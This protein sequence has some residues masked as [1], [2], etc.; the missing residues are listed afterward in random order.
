[1]YCC[2][3]DNT[4]RAE[5]GGE[6]VKHDYK[7][8]PDVDFHTEVPNRYA[9][10]NS[11]TLLVRARTEDGERDVE[12][13][14]CRTLSPACFYATPDDHTQQREVDFYKMN[15]ATRDWI[16]A[17]IEEEYVRVWEDNRLAMGEGR[18]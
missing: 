6:Q 4:E 8:I 17:D 11:H 10:G 2:G 5:S 12:V 7:W 13:C 16:D 18:E 14:V 15:Q 9:G 3:E 1:V